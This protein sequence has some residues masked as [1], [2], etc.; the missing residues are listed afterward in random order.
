MTKYVSHLR[1]N[2]LGKI[3]LNVLLELMARLWRLRS[4]SQSLFR[5]LLLYHQTI[6]SFTSPLQRNIQPERWLW[7][8]AALRSI[9]DIAF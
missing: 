8:C 7:C 3:S 5:F 1:A 4:D 9:R 6:P 2:Y